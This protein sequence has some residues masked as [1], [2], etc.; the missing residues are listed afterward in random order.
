MS[1]TPWL[2]VADRLSLRGDAGREGPAEVPRR[3]GPDGEEEARG[4]GARDAAARRQVTL[5]E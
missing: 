2:V 5:Q 1:V 3:A 4:L